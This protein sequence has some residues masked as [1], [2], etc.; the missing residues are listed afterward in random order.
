MFIIYDFRQWET[1]MAS[2]WVYVEGSLG[3]SMGNF[4]KQE[5]RYLKSGAVLCWV[6]EQL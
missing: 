2:N 1:L 4:A 5:G 6:E 3:T